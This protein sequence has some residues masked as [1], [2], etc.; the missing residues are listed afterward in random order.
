MSTL[1]MVAGPLILG[2]NLKISD[3]IIG[4]EGGT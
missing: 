1:D 3:Q 4:G 2:G